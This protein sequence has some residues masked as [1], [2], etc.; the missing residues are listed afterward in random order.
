METPRIIPP[1]EPQSSP[2]QSSCPS[3]RALYP[4]SPVLLTPPASVGMVLPSARWLACAGAAIPVFFSFSCA[5]LWAF[6]RVAA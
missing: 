2:E 4:L 6:W 3:E 1:E 5:A